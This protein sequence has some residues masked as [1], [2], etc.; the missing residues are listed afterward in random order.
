[1]ICVVVCIPSATTLERG[2]HAGCFFVVGVVKFATLIS[3]NGFIFS[4]VICVYSL[5]GQAV[6]EISNC[7]L[8]GRDKLWFNSQ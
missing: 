1:M 8:I 4:S 2:R 5:F 7:L 3:F 6:I